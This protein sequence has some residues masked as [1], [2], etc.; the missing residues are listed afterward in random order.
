MGV[1]EIEYTW[2]YVSIPSKL[3]FFWGTLANTMVTNT[4]SPGKTKERTAL[5]S[6]CLRTVRAASF[7]RWGTHAATE[8]GIKSQNASPECSIWNSKRCY[9]GVQTPKMSISH[10]YIFFIAIIDRSPCHCWT[11]PQN[12]MCNML[13]KQRMF[14]TCIKCFKLQTAPQHTLFS[15]HAAPILMEQMPW[16]NQAEFGKYDEQST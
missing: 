6:L 3:S 15:S 1:A 5:F 12:K 16:Q 9:M 11:S 13:P 2:D 8:T 14:E 4:L 10:I 7:Q